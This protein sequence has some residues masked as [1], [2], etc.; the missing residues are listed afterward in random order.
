MGKQ[1]RLDGETFGDLFVERFSH[2]SS[3]HSYW[4][5]RCECGEEKT[6]RGSHLLSGHTTSC[7][8]QKGN[9][10]HKGSRTRLYAIWSGMRERC[11]NPKSASYVYYGARGIIVCN[12][13]KDFTKFRDW[14]VANGYN[15]CLTIDR[16]DNNS[17]YSPENCRWATAREQANNT[18]KTRVLIHNGEAH[19]VSEWA[20]IL[21]I[22]Q[23]TLSMRINKYGWS[24]E[25]ALRK[26]VTK[27]VS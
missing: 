18:R 20:R 8:C 9:L 22:K 16:I 25:K 15:D 3:G 7:G 23:S 4:V 27:N 13:W 12:E 2:M 14:A 11:Y 6:I 10:S 21:G 26:V 1:K 17:G 24:A 19:S 5:C